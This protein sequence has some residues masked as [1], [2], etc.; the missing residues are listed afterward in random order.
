[1]RSHSHV[2]ERFPSFWRG[3]SGCAFPFAGPLTGLAGPDTAKLEL[4]H[5]PVICRSISSANNFTLIPQ[6]SLPP[7][8]PTQIEISP[9]PEPSK[10]QWPS[11]P[12]PVYVLRRHWAL[13]HAGP[14]TDLM[15]RC[16][17]GVSSRISALLS[18]RH[19]PPPPDAR[20]RSTRSSAVLPPP[21]SLHPE[22][23]LAAMATNRTRRHWCRHGQRLLVRLAVLDLAPN[24]RTNPRVRPLSDNFFTGTATTC[25]APGVAT[26]STPSWSR[27]APLSE[28][29][30]SGPVTHAHRGTGIGNRIDDRRQ[31]SND[32]YPILPLQPA[33]AWR[34][35]ET[36]VPCD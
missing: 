29:S 3:L 1:M 19:P 34:S 6:T 22:R 11:S 17:D 16:S 28:A 2:P 8:T 23:P 33:C 32:I 18:V 26:T 12:S 24:S 4:Q 15:D 36:R 7:P 13:R 25:P 21:R 10:S 35:K 14:R 20:Y 27:S 5:L 30:K 31:S 9:P